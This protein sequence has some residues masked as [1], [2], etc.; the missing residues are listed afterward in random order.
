M[1]EDNS[2]NLLFEIFPWNRNFETGI[3]RIDQQHKILVE[4]L[5]RLAR[6]FASNPQEPDYDRIID[7]LLDYAKFHFEE[8]E[9]IWRHALPGSRQPAATRPPR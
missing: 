5:N 4:I 3:E 1:L 7:E 2:E 6:H 9:Q 8:E